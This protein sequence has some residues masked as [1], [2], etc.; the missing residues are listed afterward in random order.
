MWPHS[1]FAVTCRLLADGAGGFAVYVRHSRLDGRRP[2][3][4]RLAATWPHYSRGG[5]R[6]WFLCP[7]CGARVGRLHLPYRGRAAEFKCRRCH[8]LTYES[9][10]LCG[11]QVR[12]TWRTLAREYGSTYAEARDLFRAHIGGYIH[13]PRVMRFG[14]RK[15]TGARRD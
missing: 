4:V 10:Q 12:R 13:R 8:G 15:I 14:P 3:F 7:A 5:A 11:S 6:W 2:Q 9:S 1:G